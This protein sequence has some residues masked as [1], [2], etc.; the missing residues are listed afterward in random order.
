MLG[1]HGWVI[2]IAFLFVAEVLVLAAWCWA[3]WHR[4]ACS[5]CGKY[6]GEALYGDSLLCLDCCERL[7]RRI[8]ADT[9]PPANEP[10]L[11]EA[12]LDAIDAEYQREFGPRG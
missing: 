11:S 10:P 7:V 3:H 6:A 4:T 2:V 1:R 12:A 9:D 8:A 5:H